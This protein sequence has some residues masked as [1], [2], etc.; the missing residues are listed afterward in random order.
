[1]KEWVG[2]QLNEQIF[3]LYTMYIILVGVLS[4]SFHRIFP[5]PI[6]I[7]KHEDVVF[8]NYSTYDE[9]ELIIH[10]KVFHLFIVVVFFH[11]ALM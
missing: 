9:C 5:E 11:T 4:I 3:L 2:L 7:Y 10:T 8:G 6:S 1:M